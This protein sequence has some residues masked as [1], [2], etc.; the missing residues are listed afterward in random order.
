[1][2]KLAMIL[3]AA[4]C[5]VLI[6]C[7]AVPYKPYAREV[8]R[9][10]STG[11]EISLKVEHRDEDRTKAQQLMDTNCSPSTAKVDEEGEVDVGTTTSSNASK[12]RQEGQAG[13]PIATLWGMPITSG[14][15]KPSEDTQTVATTTVLKEWLIK[16]SCAKAEKPVLAPAPAPLSTKKK[17]SKPAEPAKE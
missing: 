10:P 3:I 6:G 9:K 8:K 17:R 12:S 14:D 2:K 15:K 11:G 5:A 1:M 7:Q 16:Y 13:A 4:P